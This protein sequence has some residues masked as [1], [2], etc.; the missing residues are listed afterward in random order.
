VIMNVEQNPKRPEAHV[1]SELPLPLVR[2]CGI[3]LFTV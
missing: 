3:T 1:R 2:R